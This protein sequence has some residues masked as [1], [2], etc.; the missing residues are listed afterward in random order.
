MEPYVVDPELLHAFI[1]EAM[2]GLSDALPLASELGLSEGGQERVNAIFHPIHSVK[3]SAAFFG[4]MSVKAFSH[5]IEDILEGLRNGSLKPRDE[6][7]ELISGAIVELQGMLDRVKAGEKEVADAKSYAELLKSLE[8]AGEEELAF[9]VGDETVVFTRLKERLPQN[10]QPLVPWMRGVLQGNSPAHPPVVGDTLKDWESEMEAAIGHSQQLCELSE[11]LMTPSREVQ[12]SELEA[13][14]RLSHAVHDLLTKLGCL[15]L[16]DLRVKAGRMA[17]HVAEE[18]G[19]AVRVHAEGDDGVL[20]KRVYR[21]L[22]EALVHLVRNA[23][24]HGIEDESI[25]VA[26]GKSP[27]G[28]VVI[29]T[30]NSEAGLEVKV[31]DDGSGIDTQRVLEKGRELG[32]VSEDES[33]SAEELIFQPGLSTADEVT[34]LSGRGVGMDIVRRAMEKVGGSVEVLSR[35]GEGT[36]FSLTIPLP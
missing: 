25:R 14:S 20:L 4:L 27:Q 36:A 13:V 24:D 10:L 15:S 8:A 18:T 33:T 19:K 7:G 6:L 21:H 12:S 11:T 35:K 1:D 3:G 9:T 5:A 32:L 28:R 34:E 31:T 16:A 23:V 30:R 26:D 2:L 22:D 17:S 29:E